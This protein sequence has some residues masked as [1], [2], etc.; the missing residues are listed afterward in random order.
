MR[1]IAVVGSTGMLGRE[2][3]RTKFFGYEIVEINR[4]SAPVSFDNRHIQVDSKLSNIEEL[5][6][7][8]KVEYL[9]N[10]SG[11]IRQK[12]EEQSS[13]SREAALTA[14]F[15]V[16]L[17]LV[18]LSERN[19]FKI[20][21]IG[22]DCVYSGSKGNYLETDNHDATDLYGKTKSIGEIPHKNLSVIRA[23]IVGK[24]LNSQS[25]LL[26]WFLSQ[27]KA[28]VVSGFT[29]Q[30]WNGVTV[31]HFSKFVK[32]VVEGNA[33]D[34]FSG[35]HHVFPSNKVTKEKLLRIFASAFG[36]ED[37][38]VVP[39]SSGR[40]LDMTLSTNDMRFN[41]LIWKLA[42]YTRPLSIEEMIVE[43][44]LSIELGG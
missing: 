15:E 8:S 12:I 32:G 44:S 6:D 2:V 7:F 10:C 43:Y 14:N 39:V 16:P 31:G 36:R 24:E 11:L 37:I 38:E 25:S 30:L 42:G 41:D 19:N 34:T 35:I 3:A 29:D 27:P 40:G 22:T 1:Q 18:S 21:Q 26:S 23:S 20:I 13:K 9:V 28:A 17:K 5:M 33:F 4:Q